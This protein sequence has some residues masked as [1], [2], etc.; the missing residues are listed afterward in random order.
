MLRPP[1][2]FIELP[3]PD[4]EKVFPVEVSSGWG[5]TVVV[6]IETIPQTLRVPQAARAPA[7]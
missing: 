1:N 6:I 3:N 5:D 2:P 7:R 4:S